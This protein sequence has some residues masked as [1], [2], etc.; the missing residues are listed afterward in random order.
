[1]ARE[2]FSKRYGFT[3]PATEIRI[4]EDAPGFVREALLSIAC[5]VGLLPD[6]LRAI[7]CRVLRVSPDPSN[8]SAPN[9]EREVQML[10]GNADWYRVYNF[11]E[12]VYSHLDDRW[13]DGEF[14]PERW[15]REVNEYFLEAAGGWQL[16]NGSL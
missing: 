8:W 6:E 11:V 3:K 4:R 1:M 2:Q 14:L 7:L 12:A 13:A 15:Q 16:V 5:E 10:L 9:V